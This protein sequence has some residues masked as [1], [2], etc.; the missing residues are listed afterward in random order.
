MVINARNFC[1]FS[2]TQYNKIKNRNR[3][4]WGVE[5]MEIHQYFSP[6][7]YEFEF[8]KRGFKL[9]AIVE[10]P[11]DVLEEWS[12]DFAVIE[13]LPSLPP[14]RITLLAKMEG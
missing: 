11:S 1:N 14:K 8:A 13:G 2:P 7:E 12:S 6:K 5:R 4:R 10:T 9:Y 3:D